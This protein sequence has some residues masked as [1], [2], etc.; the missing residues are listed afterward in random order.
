MKLP[1]NKHA[2]IKEEKLSK[3]LLSEEHDVGKHKAK[4]F[5][6][7]GFDK[8]NEKELKRSLIKI[9]QSKDVKEVIPCQFGVKYVIDDY[10]KTPVGKVVKMRTV[11]IIESKKRKPYL[12]TA[13]PVIIDTAKKEKL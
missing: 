10:I 9:A 6:K 3:Y 13:L 8:D 5:R 4:L 1:Y 12:V 2:F 7:I 11:W